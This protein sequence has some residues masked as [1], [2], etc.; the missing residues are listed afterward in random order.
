MQ[1]PHFLSTTYLKAQNILFLID[2]PPTLG[3][4]EDTHELRNSSKAGWSN[5]LHHHSW[6][7]ILVDSNRHHCNLNW[8]VVYDTWMYGCQCKMKPCTP[9][10]KSN[11]V[12]WSHC[13]SPL[14]GEVDEKS[15]LNF[16]VALHHKVK[17]TTAYHKTGFS[18]M[19]SCENF[20]HIPKG[21]EFSTQH[22]V[23]AR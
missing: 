18:V 4:W 17:A 9:K 11:I 21:S 7:L 22:M 3:S 6:F 16:L 10:H 13:I 15:S 23:H 20:E 2:L 5:A 12:S 1:L 19:V 8:H 14:G